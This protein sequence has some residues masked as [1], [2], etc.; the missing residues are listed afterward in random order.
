MFH[1]NRSFFILSTEKFPCKSVL[2]SLCC[3]DKLLNVEKQVLIASSHQPFADLVRHS[4]SESKKY[5]LKVVLSKEELQTLTDQQNFDLVILDAD[6]PDQSIVSAISS[7]KKDQMGLKVIVFPPENRVDHPFLAGLAADAFLKKPFYL[8]DLNETVEQVFSQK[9]SDKNNGHEQSEK[10]DPEAL[11]YQHLL[12]MV[13]TDSPATAIML[14]KNEEPYA[15]VGDLEEN[16]PD[17]IYKLIAPHWNKKRRKDVV[18]FKRLYDGGK[19]YLFYAT[20]F[21]AELIL[22]V[23]YERAIALTSARYHTNLITRHLKNPPAV[24]VSAQ[25]TMPV[26]RSMLPKKKPPQEEAEEAQLLTTDDLA[27]LMD[28][29]DFGDLDEAEMIRLEELLS[30]MPAPDPDGTPEPLGLFAAEDWGTETGENFLQAAAPFTEALEDSPQLKTTEPKAENTAADG[31]ASEAVVFPWE[32]QEQKK[33]AESEHPPKKSAFSAE[34]QQTQRLGKKLPDSQIIPADHL[35]VDPLEDTAPR[36][37]RQDSEPELEPHTPG[38]SSLNYTCVLLPRYPQHYLSG[39]LGENLANWMPQLC[40]AYGWRLERISLRPQYMQWS[41]QVAPTVSPGYMV[42]ILRDETS[43]RIFK[44]KPEL[45]LENM[46]N[47]FWAP[48]YLVM[49]GYLPPTQQVLDDFIKQTRRRQ[50]LKLDED[51]RII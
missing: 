43:R 5:K 14:V 39:I 22:V 44:I 13:M 31:G 9:Q 50:G 10:I 20:A 17:Q 11:Y 7:L 12:N 33:S 36:I 38:V 40:I 27:S 26:P 34:A 1:F 30:S 6:L 35:A 28:D 23:V 8:P 15:F 48:G 2:L 42:R 51:D 18:R 37:I 41:I 3:S 45:Q 24:W 32:E 4:L 25:R 47:D 19:D 21:G 29:E 46:L 16:S 49:S